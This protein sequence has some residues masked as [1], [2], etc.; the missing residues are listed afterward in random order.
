MLSFE[1][2]PNLNTLPNNSPSVRPAVVR[3]LVFLFPDENLCK[4]LWICT[5]LDMCIDI[6]KIWFGI[7]KLA[8]FVNFDRFICMRH[9]CMLFPENNL[10]KYQWTYTKLGLCIDV[11]KISFGIANG[12]ILS[13]FD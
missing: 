1:I 5:K 3:P 6:V 8:N 12:H 7:A 11:V 10:S 13:S 4:C 2:N 9:L